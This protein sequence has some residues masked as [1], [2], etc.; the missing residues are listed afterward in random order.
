MPDT[1]KPY[2]E[3]V[4]AKQKAFHTSK[5]RFRLM[6]GAYGGG[7]S[8]AAVIEILKECWIYPGNYGYVLRQSFK[9]I[10]QTILKDIRNITPPWMIVQQHKTSH[11]IDL[12]Q[13]QRS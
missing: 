8:A 13:L 1:G 11:W 4:G 10:D 2:R 9:K 3:T 5:S 7:K 6:S 12:A